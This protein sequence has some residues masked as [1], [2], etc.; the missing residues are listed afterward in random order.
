MP[1]DRSKGAGLGLRRTTTA[2]ATSEGASWAPLVAA[3]AVDLAD[4]ATAGPLGLV[5]GLFVGFVLTGAVSLS[6]GARRR[7]ALLFATLGALY[8]AFPLTEALPLATLLTLVHGFVG[9]RAQALREAEQD[10]G[11][12]ATDI[13]PDMRVVQL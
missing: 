4:F 3:L 12:S 9:R 5:A 8:C 11:P 7:Q 1:E 2:L 10:P 13:D 6:A